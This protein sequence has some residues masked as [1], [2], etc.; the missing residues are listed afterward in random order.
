MR[1]YVTGGWPVD[2]AR[3]APCVH[4]TTSR[5]VV[6]RAQGS[7][8]TRGAK[9][10]R[11]THRLVA[12][13]SGWA[14]VKAGDACV[15]LQ[16]PRLLR[17]Q[18]SRQ[19]AARWSPSFRGGRAKQHAHGQSRRF[20]YSEVAPRRIDPASS[21]GPLRRLGRS[22]VHDRS[23]WPRCLVSLEEP[24]VRI[25]RETPGHPSRDV[26]WQVA[27][28]TTHTDLH[29]RQRRR[30]SLRPSWGRPSLQ[31]PRV[32]RRPRE[33]YGLTYARYFLPKRLDGA[34]EA[35]RAYF[36]LYGSEDPTV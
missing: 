19:R 8:H 28:R 3:E 7:R 29:H 31:L 1:A 34:R 32:L 11:S 6:W 20:R 36:A 35:I 5:H 14:R 22:R 26:S 10:S 17:W 33:S 16:A 12:A 27:A 13:I 30:R 24:G 2:D 15:A 4:A 18:R 23:N 25:K 21:A 9:A